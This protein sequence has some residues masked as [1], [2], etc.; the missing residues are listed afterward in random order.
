MSHTGSSRTTEVERLTSFVDDLR[1]LRCIAFFKLSSIVSPQAPM[2]KHSEN[3]WP[4]P[5]PRSAPQLI[6]TCPTS[7]TSH[8]LQSHYGRFDRVI[9]RALRN[10][11]PLREVSER[12]HLHARIYSA[13]CLRMPLNLAFVEVSQVQ[14]TTNM[15]LSQPQPSPPNERRPQFEGSTSMHGFSSSWRSI[16]TRMP[17][18]S[19]LSTS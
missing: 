14:F 10:P 12:G 2:R 3:A 13:H 16:F 7:W 8:Y 19:L 15:A 6:S 9:I 4:G 5:S 18:A 11:R 1:T 17:A